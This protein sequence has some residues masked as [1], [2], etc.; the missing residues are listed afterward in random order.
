LPSFSEINASRNTLWKQCFNVSW[1]YKSALDYRRKMEVSFIGLL[2]GWWSG[3]SGRVPAQQAWA[4]KFK[5]P[6]TTKKKK[7]ARS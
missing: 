1:S 5:P 6:S 4:P 2:G 3:S 7:R